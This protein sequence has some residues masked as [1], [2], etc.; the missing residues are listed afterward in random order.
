MLNLHLIKTGLILSSA[1]TGELLSI[2]VNYD[3]YCLRIFKYATVF[4]T[5]LGINYSE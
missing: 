4:Q 3:L 2:C 1:N 5:L